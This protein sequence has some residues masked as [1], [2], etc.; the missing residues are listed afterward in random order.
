MYTN[1]CIKCGK[2]FETKNPKRVICPDCLY[3]EKGA[4]PAAPTDENGA[5][6]DYSRGYSA[7]SENS[8]RFQRRYNN[9]RPQNENYKEAVANY[10]KYVQL[11]NQAGE[12]DELSDFANSRIKELKEYLAS[13]K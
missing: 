13:L 1:K 9:P 7:G 10:E 8:E 2:E 12:K 11:K 3:P 5:V 6:A 4:T